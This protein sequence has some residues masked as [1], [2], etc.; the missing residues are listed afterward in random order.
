MA[1]LMPIDLINIIRGDYV[2]TLHKHAPTNTGIEAWKRNKAT[3]WSG[4]IDVMS[5]IKTCNQ[6]PPIHC[7]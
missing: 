7:N 6:L 4:L 2:A 3:K 1:N 5:L